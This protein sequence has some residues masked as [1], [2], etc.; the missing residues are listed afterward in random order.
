[1]DIFPG[2][3][4]ALTRKQTVKIYNRKSK[5]RGITGIFFE[6]LKISGT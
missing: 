5:K 1:M 4:S 3:C 2:E 6:K